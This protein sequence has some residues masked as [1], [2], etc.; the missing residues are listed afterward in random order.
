MSTDLPKPPAP[1][2]FY[3]MRMDW[4][5]FLSTM[6]AVSHAEFRVAFFIAMRMNGRDQSSWWEVKQIA[7][8]IGCSTNTVSDA[9]TKLEQLGLMV[10]VRSKRAG[11][12]YSIRMPDHRETH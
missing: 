11:N 5:D 4:L 6:S 10:V 8:Q 12:R 9:T 1:A 3:K 2:R 7:K